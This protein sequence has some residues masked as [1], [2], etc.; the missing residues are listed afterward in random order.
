MDSL[1]RPVISKNVIILGLVSLFNDFASEMVYPVVPLLLTGLLGSPV[2]I[3]GLIEGIAESTASLLKGFFGWYSDKLQKRKGFAVWGYSL[4]TAAKLVIGF[5]GIWPIVLLGRFLDRFGK[6]VRTAARDALI[7]ESAEPEARGRAF[8]FHRAMD[9]AGAVIGPL[10]AMWLILLFK[11]DLRPIFYI[12][13]IP[14][15]VGVILLMIFVKEVRKE[16]TAVEKLK[17]DWRNIDSSFKLF[18]LASIIFALGNSSDAFLILRAKNLGL[19][20]FYSVFAFVTFNICFALSSYPAG[21]I[22]DKIG[23]KKLLQA[24]FF[25][26]AAI[27]LL[28]GLIDKSVYIWFLFPAYGIY[29]GISEG[30]GKAFITNLVPNQKSGT[31]L[32]IYQMATGICAFFAS[33]FAGLL[34]SRISPSAPFFYGSAMAFIAGLIFLFFAPGKNPTLSFTKI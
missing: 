8:G 9:T 17:L 34:W 12:A 31:V 23:A 7:A 20:A 29:M 2:S 25:A 30:I 11:N 26:F 6:G 3:V 32:G 5:A 33:L 13:F 1:N 10:C 4:S 24:G 28:F 22:S 19:S 14:G 21:I 27:Y 15:A 16:K 18:L